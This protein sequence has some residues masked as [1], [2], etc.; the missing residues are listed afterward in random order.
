MYVNYLV[1][2]YTRK[3]NLLDT[4]KTSAVQ[5]N[6]NVDGIKFSCEKLQDLDLSTCNKIVLYT[7]P[8]DD[9]KIHTYTITKYEYDETQGI[10]EL[11]WDFSNIITAQD[12]FIYF[13]V[14]FYTIEND[15]ITKQWNSTKDCFKVF[16]TIDKTNSVPEY[17][18][19]EKATIMEQISYLFTKWD[20]VSDSWTDISSKFEKIEPAFYDL[21][22]LVKG[23]TSVVIDSDS[24]IVNSYNKDDD[25]NSISE[26]IISETNRATSKEQTLYKSMIETASLISI[27]TT[28]VQNDTLFVKTVSKK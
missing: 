25:F 4:G 9:S 13:S 2:T 8:D 18:D 11:Y 6:V 19:D 22:T 26:M 21:Q 3:L 24:I 1:N 5:T 20:Q 10:Y 17:T 28:D 7:T 12:G 27:G 14:C 23:G 15:N 16:P